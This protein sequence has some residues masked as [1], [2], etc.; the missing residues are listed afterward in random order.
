[1]GQTLNKVYPKRANPATV[2]RAEIEMPVIWVP[3]KKSIP[4]I[5]KVN[6]PL[7]KKAAP[8]PPTPT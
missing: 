7:L 4:V 2:R 6:K 3:D 8:R 1:M 5:D